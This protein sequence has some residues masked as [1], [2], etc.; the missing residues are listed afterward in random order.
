MEIKV[1]PRPFV[2][3][4]FI[5]GVQ[6][7]G[8][9]VSGDKEEL[10]EDHCLKA[11][12]TFSQSLEFHSALPAHVQRAVEL[13]IWERRNHLWTSLGLSTGSSGFDLKFFPDI[14]PDNRVDYVLARKRWGP[15]RAKLD[16]PA[17][18][19]SSGPDYCGTW[20]LHSSLVRTT[21]VWS[22]CAFVRRALLGTTKVCKKYRALVAEVNSL[23]AA[24]RS[25]FVAW[26][27]FDRYVTGQVQQIMKDSPEQWGKL[28]ESGN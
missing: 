15:F 22:E 12:S 21:D 17:G 19:Y 25:L 24:C 26:T 18:R 1:T 6:K 14:Q 13:N 28:F 11:L 27:R 7:T 4:S 2:N 16:L 20:R 5:T 10:S 3:F 9:T 23:S 8:C